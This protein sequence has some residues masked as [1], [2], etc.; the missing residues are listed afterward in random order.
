MEAIPRSDRQI[1][2]AKRDRIN[3]IVYCFNC[4]LFILMSSQTLVR[5]YAGDAARDADT[6]MTLDDRDRRTLFQSA[7]M[8]KVEM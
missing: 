5:L 7:S 4:G 8:V 1:E 2:T 3:S 6:I